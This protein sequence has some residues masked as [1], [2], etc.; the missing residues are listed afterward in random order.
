MR[1]TGIAIPAT[2]SSAQGNST[3]GAQPNTRCDNLARELVVK[4]PSN[5]LK[6]RKAETNRLAWAFSQRRGRQARP[7]TLKIKAPAI[8]Q[9]AAKH[10]TAVTK[11]ATTAK[12]TGGVMPR[13][14]SL[15]VQVVPPKLG[16]G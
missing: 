8:L 12:G 3:V 16:Q 9:P 11:Q 10:T 1:R 15:N 7:P 5:N 2:G 13:Q 14:A 6:R 4:E